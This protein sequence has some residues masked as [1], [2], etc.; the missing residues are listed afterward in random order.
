MPSSPS[1]MV[2]H[3]LDTLLVTVTVGERKEFVLGLMEDRKESEV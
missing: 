2:Q 3:A 1:I